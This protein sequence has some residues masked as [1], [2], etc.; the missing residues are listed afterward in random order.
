MS[1]LP[2]AERI[3]FPS[4]TLFRLQKQA[5]VPEDRLTAY[6]MLTILLLRERAPSA[7]GSHTQLQAAGACRGC[8][9]ERVE[10]HRSGGDACSGAGQGPSAVLATA[11][12]T[13]TLSMPLFFRRTSASSSAA[14]PAPGHTGRS[15]RRDQCSVNG[16]L[17]A[18]RQ[19]QAIGDHLDAAL[20]MSV[21][22]Q[23][24]V[25]HQDMFGER[26]PASRQTRAAARSSGPPRARRT[27][28]RGQA[29]TWS[30][31]ASSGRPL[32]HRAGARGR[33][34]RKRRRSRTRKSAESRASSGATGRTLSNLAAQG[35]DCESR[36]ANSVSPT[37]QRCSAEARSSRKREAERCQPL[38]APIR[39]I[40]VIGIV[41]GGMGQCRGKSALPQQRH[42]KPALGLAQATTRGHCDCQELEPGS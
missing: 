28:D 22:L 16:K 14:S 4:R 41:R 7:S 33:G 8:E 24:Q 25:S 26:A 12:C 19:R 32:R 18:S 9:L 6:N 13:A 38:P 15:K 11:C 27:P 21:C 20:I 36:S 34:S 29:A 3:T 31:T 42:R 40:G 30:P 5:A 35:P 2:P 37:A 23:V 10:E 1:V 39:D 17:R